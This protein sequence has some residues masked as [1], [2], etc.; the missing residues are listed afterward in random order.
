MSHV[1]ALGP[2]G[3]EWTYDKDAK[4]YNLTRGN[5]PSTFSLRTTKGPTDTSITLAPSLS[6]LIVVDM[7]NLFLH[8]SCNKHPTGLAAVE[9][10]IELVRKCR[11]VDVKIIWLN[12]GLNDKDLETMPAA[13]ERSFDRTLLTMPPDGTQV[14][15]GFGFDMGEGRGRLLMDGS[16]NAALY[17]PMRDETRSSDVFCSKNRISGLWHSETPLGKELK[18]GG[19][20]TLLFAGVN[21]DQCV[22]G[23]LT[24][25][26]YHGYDC[27]MVE[28]CCATGTPRG[29]EVTISNVSGLY[30]FVVDSHSIIEGT[31]GSEVH[32]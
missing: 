31:L 12:W 21:T 9:R 8:P 26:Y 22:L 25:A 19:F 14:R 7:Q 29:Q 23:T 15:R 4:I 27:I 5:S 1:V 13:A 32:K 17:G 2:R 18:S 28:D 6:A 24:D 11:E 16:W 10:T 20:R 30:G 3:D